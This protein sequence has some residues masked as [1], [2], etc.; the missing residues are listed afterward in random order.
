[1]ETVLTKYSN[2]SAFFLAMNGQWVESVTDAHVWTD[3]GE[4]T[5]LIRNFARTGL[6]IDAVAGFGM[7][8]EVTIVFGAD[9]MKGG[10]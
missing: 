4:I 3:L 6:E 5:N 1:M 8:E 9:F 10:K 2:G 7:I